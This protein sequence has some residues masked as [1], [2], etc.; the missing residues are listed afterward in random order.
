MTQQNNIPTPENMEDC[1]AIQA[2][3][4]GIPKITKNN[5]EVFFERGKALQ[6]LGVGFLTKAVDSSL[7]ED[8]ARMPTLSEVKENIGLSWEDEKTLVRLDDKGWKN[9]VYQMVSMQTKTLIQRE[10]EVSNEN[11]GKQ[12]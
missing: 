12:T 8:E 2:Y 1:L 7:E 11:G 9:A 10:G 5:Y 4:V 6:L 3:F